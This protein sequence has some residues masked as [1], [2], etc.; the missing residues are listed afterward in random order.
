M[1]DLI[2]DTLRHKTVHGLLWSSVERF[3]VQGITFVTSILIARQ[4][5]PGEYGTIAMLYIFIG[6]SNS[7]VDS[8]FSTAL[9]RKANRSE[10]DNATV[11]YFNI[12]VGLFCMVALFFCAPMIADFYE[13]PVLN[14]VAR[15]ISVVLF[16]D[17][18]SVVQRALLTADIDF[19]TQA[20]V[21]LS[22]VILSGGAGLW[23][24]YA[25]WGV[26][27]LAW[28]MVTASLFRSI[29]FWSV[30]RWRPKACFSIDSF[31]N[32]FGFGSKLLLSG[33]IDTLYN[34]IYIL[35]IGKMFNASS[36]GNYSRARQI[37]YYPSSNLTE[38][39]QRVTFPVMSTLQHEDERLRY[40]YRLMLRLSGFI[41]F[42]LMVGL[43]L[44][45]KPL[46]LFLLTPEWSGAIPL[47]QIISLGLMW[48]PIHAI[49]L[50]LLQVKGRSDLFLRVEIIKKVIGI[51]VLC[52]TIPMGL[53]A[54]CWG[55]VI[56]SIIG[57]VINTYYTGKLINAGFI[58]QMLDL[59]PILF[60]TAVMG[61]IVYLCIGLSQKPSTQLILGI[62]SG[63]TA[64]LILTNSFKMKELNYILDIIKKKK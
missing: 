39:L 11:F 46:I 28:Q 44:V 35:V 29:L 25:G 58:R 4:L 12:W 27:A 59:L 21:S 50:N 23:L 43:A 57:L 42:P 49:N 41:V 38:V 20:K 60:T 9:V 30:A 15:L 33:L 16:L 56:C 53:I 6:I 54:M 34:N 55:Q 26:W 48:Y 19:K 45:A 61:G 24:A 47:L 14:P 51:S 36:L 10:T 63:I 2:E 5:L 1:K 52:A 8:G 18:L 17:S 62:T 3:S 32:L 40:T 31:R 64:Y 37:A 13:M 7:L 22:S